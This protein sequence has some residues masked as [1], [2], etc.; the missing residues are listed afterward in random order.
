[1][2]MEELEAAVTGLQQDKEAAAT[3]QT[4]GNFQNKFGSGWSGDEGLGRTFFDILG[5]QDADLEDAAFAGAVEKLVDQCMQETNQLAQKLKGFQKQ[6]QEN[7]EKM[8]AIQQAAE[9]VGISSTPAS[10]VPS[11]IPA[12]GD[13]PAPEGDVPPPPE[14][15]DMGDDGGAPPPPDMGGMPP[16]DMGSGAPPP[17]PTDMGMPPPEGGDMG[18]SPPPP[19]PPPPPGVP[20]DKRIKNVRLP[21][22]AAAAPKPKLWKPSNA[23]LNGVRNGI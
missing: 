6:I 9:A 15:G 17:A 19:P 7:A 10:D 4:F 20:S 23:L 3:E 12:V 21:T 11:E 16:P 22:A 18:M 5:A 2:T 14:G 1:M 8:E 13:A